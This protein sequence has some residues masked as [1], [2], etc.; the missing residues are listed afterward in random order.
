MDWMIRK[1]FEN[2]NFI[3]RKGIA[4]TEYWIGQ[5]EKALLFENLLSDELDGIKGI[6]K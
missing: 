6:T 4:F 5:L 2:C 1:K 3:K